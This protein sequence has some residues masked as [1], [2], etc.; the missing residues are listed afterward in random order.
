MGTE[1]RL[2]GDRCKGPGGWICVSIRGSLEAQCDYSRGSEVD[3]G[4]DGVWRLAQA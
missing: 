4:Q 2:W 3:C 1:P